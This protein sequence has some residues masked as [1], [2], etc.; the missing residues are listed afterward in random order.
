MELDYLKE[1]MPVIYGEKSIRLLNLDVRQP[2]A[3]CF[4]VHWHE[5]IEVIFVK[6]GK[7]NLFVDG[8]KYL[9]E[10]NGTAVIMPGK[11]HN[12]ISGER[13]VVYTVV[14]F[15][16]AS[17][18]NKTPAASKYFNTASLDRSVFECISYNLAIKNTV[19][20]IEKHYYSD[21]STD[22]IRIISDI[23]TLIAEI[24]RTMFIRTVGS[25]KSDKKFDNVLGYIEENF[26]ENITSKSL[27][28]EFGYDQ[29]YFCRK[30]KAIT[31][32]S[33]VKYINIL[34]LEKAQKL[35]AQTKNSVSEI[36]LLCGFKDANYFTRC[37]KT[38]FG[39]TPTEAI[40]N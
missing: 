19:E 20:N 15:D 14:M 32:I 3:V 2:N 18:M 33:P 17:F 13:G 25:N 38:Q 12:G 7:L 27:S 34:R 31:G 30:F 39:I 24:Y 9:L 4:N 1:L 35:L 28:A 10:K 36:A 21:D 22:S 29:A 16:I 37:F 5:R 6:S 23:Y 8:K 40:P 11:L 26:C